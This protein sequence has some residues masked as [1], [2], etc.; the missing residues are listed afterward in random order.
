MLG[1]ES[2]LVPFEDSDG[3]MITEIDK[4]S[5]DAEWADIV[6]QIVDTL[7][8]GDHPDDVVLAAE[9][10]IAGWPTYKISKKLDVSKLTI[11]RWLTKYPSMAAAVSYGRKMMSAWRMAR[12]E[13][14]FLSATERSQEILDLDLDAEGV[15]V[16]LVGLLAQHSRFIIS[17]FAGQKVDID[18]NVNHNNPVLKAREDA[19]DYIAKAVADNRENADD[20]PIEA[21][22]T[23]VDHKEESGPVIDEEGE[24]FHGEMGV[25][26]IDEEG[27][28][29]HICGERFR[30]LSLHIRKKHNLSNDAYEITF[31]LDRNTVSDSAKPDRDK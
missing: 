30:Y 29:C 14:Q 18:I 12:L 11:R 21:I 9:Y 23:V 5:P 20:E 27:V 25:L 26:D 10:M 22:F 24:P 8:D 2:A 28:L 6:N 17:L 7:R 16:K 19:L 4:L 1:N 31:M 13:Q 3:G 15:N